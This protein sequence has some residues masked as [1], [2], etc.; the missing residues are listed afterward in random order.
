MAPDVAALIRAT[1]PSV[2][3]VFPS[4]VIASAAKQSMVPQVGAG[5]L[6]C[7]RNERET[8]SQRTAVIPREGGGSSTPRPIDSI[9]NASGILDHPPSRVMTTEYDFAFSR[10]WSPELCI[11]FALIEN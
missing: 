7:A 1:G 6:R 11:S 9:I 4:A 3:W 10:R 5:L 2:Y 8:A